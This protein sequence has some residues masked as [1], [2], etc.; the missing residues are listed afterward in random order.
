L[1]CSYGR[2]CVEFVVVSVLLAD[3]VQGLFKLDALLLV[4]LKVGL[5]FYES[6]FQIFEGFV[7][8]F[9]GCKMFIKL[10]GLLIVLIFILL[11]RLL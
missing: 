8:Y 5:D 2:L 3:L 6:R 4:R 11:D 9:H 10:V 7:L 1:L